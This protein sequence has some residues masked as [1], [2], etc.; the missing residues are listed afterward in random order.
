[1]IHILCVAL[2]VGLMMA[3]CGRADNASLVAIDSLIVQNPDSAYQLLATMPADSLTSDDDR[4]YH[5]LLTTIADYKAYHPITSDSLIN[6]AITHYD[7][8]GTNPDKRMRSLLYKGAVMNELG[9]PEDAVEYYKR[10]ESVCDTSDVYHMGYINMR[11]ATLYQ[12]A[13]SDSMAIVNYRKALRYFKKTNNKH[14]E[15]LCLNSLGVLY[16]QREKYD[17]AMEELQKGISLAESTKD[18]IVLC[19]GYNALCHLLYRRGLYADVVKVSNQLFKTNIH[20]AISRSGYDIVSISFSKLGFP[21]SASKYFEMAPKPLVVEDT[22]SEMCAIAELALAKGD[23]NTYIYNNGIAV[24]KSDSLLLSSQAEKIR[25]VEAKYDVAQQTVELLSKQKRLI[26]IIAILALVTVGVS[27][28]VYFQRKRLVLI[29]IEN[30]EAQTRL[31]E[32]KRNLEQISSDSKK[33]VNELREQEQQLLKMQD[34]IKNLENEKQDM[35]N[36]ASIEKQLKQTNDMLQS[37]EMAINI[38]RKTRFCLDEILRQSYYSGKYNSDHVI[39]NDSSLEMSQKFWDSIH[40][41]V[42]LKYD[43]LFERIAQKGVVLTA[44]EKRLLSLC[45]IN[46][47]SAIIRRML[48]YK[49]IQVVTNQKR[50]LALKVTSSST[51]IDDVFA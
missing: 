1:M 27:S 3:G 15:S 24:N 44:N 16:S 45:S 14:Y 6:I 19:E 48:N 29:K 25:Q 17:L 47:P 50:K 37:T 13:N 20:N 5:A 7:H 42:Q 49:S 10:A 43:N 32:L 46:I 23:T 41:V 4:A 26:L 36:T 40:E 39:D 8:D 30:E 31:S 28:I 34:V 21:D 12:L 18:T 35:V 38:Q 33:R 2:T 11:K 9:N 22:I 51:R